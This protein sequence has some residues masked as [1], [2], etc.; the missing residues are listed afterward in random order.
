MTGIKCSQCGSVEALNDIVYQ[1]ADLVH[2][3]MVA[4]LKLVEDIYTVVSI[5]GCNSRF[6]FY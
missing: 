2:P 4:G 3:Y 1:V 5:N 6:S